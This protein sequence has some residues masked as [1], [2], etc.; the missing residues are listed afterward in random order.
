MQHLDLFFRATRKEYI[1]GKYDESRFIRRYPLHK[2]LTAVNEVGL[3]SGKNV[4]STALYIH[5]D[6][7]CVISIHKR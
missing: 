7:V 6:N 1:V 3:K 4:H 2:D 5:N